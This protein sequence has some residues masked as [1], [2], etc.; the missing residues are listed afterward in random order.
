MRY[1]PGREDT[2]TAKN[3]ELEAASVAELCPLPVG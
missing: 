1:L 2:L 3:G